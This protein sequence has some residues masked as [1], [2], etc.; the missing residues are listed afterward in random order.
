VTSITVRQC[1]AT[2]MSTALV[3]WKDRGRSASRTVMTV[4]V[5]VMERQLADE[6]VASFR[7]RGLAEKFFYWFP[8]SVRAWLEL[9]SDSE[10]DLA[11]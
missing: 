1:R 7:A 3:G 9:C 8:L 10:Y 11:C 4:T 6:F 2:T 5:L